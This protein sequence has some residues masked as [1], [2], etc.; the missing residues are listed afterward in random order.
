MGKTAR[1][2]LLEKVRMQ[3]EEKVVPVLEDPAAMVALQSLLERA[4]LQLEEEAVM[5]LTAAMEISG[6]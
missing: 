6:E 5:D 1:P 4:R 2:S 3:P